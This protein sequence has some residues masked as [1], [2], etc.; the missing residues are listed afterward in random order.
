M[1]DVQAQ[2]QAKN[3]INNINRLKFYHSIRG[4]L[5][6]QLKRQAS[7]LVPSSL[8]AIAQLLVMATRARL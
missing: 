2:D 7:G 5:E 6:R 4:S 3:D 1:Y 8:A